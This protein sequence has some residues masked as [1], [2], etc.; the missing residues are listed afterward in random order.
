MLGQQLPHNLAMNIGEADVPAPEAM[1]KGLMVHSKEVEQG[2][3]QVMH[4]QTP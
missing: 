2:S 1:S 3:V 4:L